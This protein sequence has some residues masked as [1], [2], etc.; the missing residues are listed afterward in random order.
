M[1]V[2]YFMNDA[3]ECACGYLRWLLIFTG[4]D[5]LSSVCYFAVTGMTD[6]REPFCTNGISASA[7]CCFR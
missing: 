4:N 2:T 6:N 7:V 3:L 5:E 1:Y